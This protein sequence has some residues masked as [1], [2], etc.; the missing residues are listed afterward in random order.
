VKTDGGYVVAAPSLHA[1]G[2]RYQ[3]RTRR[4]PASMP[5][6]LLRLL[7]TEK[8]PAAAKPAAP[9]RAPATTQT[10]PLIPH[11]SRN[12]Q[13][14]RLACALRGDGATPDEIERAVFDAYEQRC[15]HEPPM[16]PSELR[17]I[18]RSASRYPA[19]R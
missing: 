1:S 7:T 4:S 10:G 12:T 3:W 19:G 6:W 5:G 18:A 14:F 9:R 8:P 16:E 13:L 2:K 11:R 15:V 17:K